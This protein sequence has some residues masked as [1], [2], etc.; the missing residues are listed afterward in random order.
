ME[1]KTKTAYFQ[2]LRLFAAAAVVLMHTAANRWMSISHTEPQ[3]EV[4]T[5]WDSLVRWPVPIFIMITGALFLPRKTAMKQALVRYIPRMAV[6]YLVWSAVYNLYERELTVQALVSGHYHLWY[7]PFLCGVYLVLPFLQKI[8]EDDRLTDQLLA[9]SL[10][11]GIAI[12]WAGN[13][14]TFLLPDGA[15]LLRQLE[16]MVNYTFFFDHIA[17]L[18]LGHKL[19]K[20]DLSPRLRRLI[21]L[22]GLL[23][24][25]VTGAATIWAT[26]RADFQNSLFFDF[27]APNNLCAAVALFVF[28][29][30]HLTKLP[31]VVNHLAG[32]SFGIYLCHALVIETLADAGI[33]VLA[34]D[35]VFW[36]PVLAAVVFAIS[37]VVSAVLTKIPLIGKYLA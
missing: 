16:A 7:L 24:V 20:T 6:C 33:H 30:Y 12:P 25:A 28:A 8:A 37:A 4:L 10:V 13:V 26:R 27:T 29:K 31:T 22:L 3:W 15:P 14:L 5:W 21:Y 34:Q 9:A 1:S 2:W 19:H 11:I 23:G 18:I 36:T 35:P 32:L 17:L